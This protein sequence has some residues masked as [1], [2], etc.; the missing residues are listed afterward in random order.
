ME[1]A[2]SITMKRPL[3][4]LSAAV[5]LCAFGDVCA[6]NQIVV[7]ERGKAATYAIVV[8]EKASPSQHYAAEELRDF[9]ERTTG[10]RLPIVTDAEVLPAKAILLGRT[11]HTD[12]L[13]KDQSFAWGKLGTDGFRLVARPPHLLVLGAPDRGTLYGVYELLERF[14]GCRWY[15][16]WHSVIPTRERFAVPETLDDT[17][18]PAFAMRSL[19][20]YDVMQNNAFAARLRATCRT[21]GRKDEKYGG[22]P[23]RFGGGLGSCHTFSRLVPPKEFFG[24]HPEYFSLVNG[25]RV[26]DGQLCLANPDVLRVVTERGLAAI[27]RD[28]TAKYYGVSQNDNKSYCRCQECAAVD[29]EE[30][31][32]AGTVVHF[33][34][35]VAEAV[36]KEFPDKVIETLAYEYSR[37]PPKKTRLRHNVMP[38]LCSIECDF[39]RPFAT[40]PYP[41][42]AAFVR[43]LKGWA[44]QTDRLYVW[45]YV[46]NFT[47]YTHAF[48]N[49]LVM[50]DNLRLFRDSGVKSVFAQGDCEARH[51]WFAELK[52]WLLAKLMWNPD[53]PVE[54]LLDRFFAGYYGKAAP[55]ARSYFDMAHKMEREWAGDSPDRKMGFAEMLPSPA[56]GDDFLQKAEALWRQAADAVK[57]EADV[58]RYNVRMSAFSDLYTRFMQQKRR[59][60]VTRTPERH[61]CLADSAERAEWLSRCA[62]EGKIRVAEGNNRVVNFKRRLKEAQYAKGGNSAATADVGLFVFQPKLAERVKD[63]SA[64]EGMSIFLPNT[65]GGWAAR[66]PM[67]V[68]AYDDG[69]EY[70]VRLRLRTSVANGALPSD[71]VFHAFSYDALAKR[72]AGNEFS[73]KVGDVKDGWAWYDVG[74]IRLN[75]KIDLWICPGRFD[76]KTHRANPAHSG[77]W[78]DGVEISRAVP[79]SQPYEGHETKCRL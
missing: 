53:Q 12:A 6:A 46:V 34:N 66:F 59:L 48:P 22:N 10:V 15:A 2:E 37:K 60:V 17:Q 33:V 49:V 64:E 70:V 57:N 76:Q 40:S 51:A 69:E 19:W 75:D 1:V 14:A 9:T 28:P 62:E 27:R 5:I 13:L 16:S 56:L 68:V 77:V 24:N 20:W 3:A 47:H 4:I 26:A 23:F 58:Y 52:A 18:T 31:S 39:S 42:N 67:R 63:P 43:D 7:A 78:V 30:E 74:K 41:Q 61:G 21:G 25:K 73:L 8:P 71:E 65:H 36:E 55:Y 44:D 29:A 32:H 11:R 38:C 35:A 79:A 50:Q 45:D 72:V 54:P